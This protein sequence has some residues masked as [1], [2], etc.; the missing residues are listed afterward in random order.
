MGYLTVMFV[1]AVQTTFQASMASN[2]SEASPFNHDYTSFALVTI[3]K[4]VLPRKTDL[5]WQSLSM[6]QK[7]QVISVLQNM[8]HQDMPLAR[9]TPAFVPLSTK[10][11]QARIPRFQINPWFLF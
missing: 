1:K 10:V 5:H 2:P 4:P 8:L 9:P 3:T 11:Q 7:D 6:Q